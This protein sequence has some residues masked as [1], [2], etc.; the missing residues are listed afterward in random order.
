MG[1]LEVMGRLDSGS[2][3]L[4]V[5]PEVW[6]EMDGELIQVP[7][8]YVGISGKIQVLHEA[9]LVIFRIEDGETNYLAYPMPTAHLGIKALVPWELA[10]ELGAELRNI[11][12][13]FPGRALRSDD[14]KWIRGKEVFDKKKLEESQREKI[15]LVIQD[16]MVENKK[17]PVSTRCTLKGAKFRIEIKANARPT[18]K[19]Q[20]PICERFWEQ[21]KQRGKEWIEKGWVKLWPPGST[22]EWHSPLLAVKKV[23]GNKWNGSKRGIDPHKV[24][25]FAL[26]RRPK[27]GKEVQKVLGYLNFLRDFIPLYANIVGPMEGLRSAKVIS[28]NLWKES[29]GEG[30][31]ELAK[32]VLSEAPILHNLDWTLEF[33]LET[34]TSQYGVG[35]ILYQETE[36]GKRYVDFAAKAFNKAQQNYN[37]TKRELLAGLYAMNHWRPWLLFRKFTWG[38][39]FKAVSFINTLTNQVVLDWIN[40]FMDFDFETRFKRGILNVLPHQLSHMYD[41]LQLDF[42][43]GENLG[44]VEMGLLESGVKQ[45]GSVVAVA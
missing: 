2:D 28:N 45:V 36:E 44:D 5:D 35:A 22:P 20:Y 30:A 26:M 19:P 6:G 17:L 41:M 42:G 16:A 1:N 18:N 8:V 11:P 14:K 24:K 10:R 39:D 13:F 32:K 34:D 38:L 31:F 29:G 12:K 15:L 4:M 27:T 23:S 9:K 33:F 37:A 25:V 3:Y 40:I 21:V 43:R 7:I